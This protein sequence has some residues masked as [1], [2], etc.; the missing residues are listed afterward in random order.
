MDPPCLADGPLKDLKDA[1]YDLYLGAETPTLDEIQAEVNA[2][3][4]SMSAL[5]RRGGLDEAGAE[6]QLDQLEGALPR[7]DTIGRIIG[8]PALPP[9]QADLVV[10]VVALAR[11]AG[12]LP[13]HTI[14]RD[15]PALVTQARRLWRRART[16]PVPLRLGKPIRDCTALAL[17][18]HRAIDLPDQ[19]TDLPRYVPR[20]HDERLREAVTACAGGTSLMITLVGGSSTGK[21][22]ACWEAVQA[23]PAQWRLWHPLDPS[24]P[25]AAASDIAQVGPH[26]VVWLN[27]A[28]FYLLGADLTLNER[29]SAGLR[30]LLNDPGRG[31]VLVLATMWPEYWTALTS[32]PPPD[33]PDR[34]AQARELLAGTDLRIPDSFHGADLRSARSAARSDARLSMAVAQSGSG[35]LTQYLAGVPELVQRCRNAPAAARAVIEAAVD[36]RRFGHPPSLSSELLQAAA[37][38]YLHEVDLGQA[39]PQWVERAFG[40]ALE[41]CHGVAGILSVVRAGPDR[42]FGLFEE[43]AYRL[44]DYL[45]QAGREERAEVFP[46]GAFWD[47]VAA[48]VRDPDVLRRIGERAESRGRNGRAAQLY[49]RSARFGDVGA[50]VAL[51][52]LRQQADD[53][54]GA[55]AF[56]ALAAD[57]GSLEAWEHRA[58]LWELRGHGVDDSVTQQRL[59]EMTERNERFDELYGDWMGEDEVTS[60]LRRARRLSDAG[61]LAQ[62]RELYGE[63]TRTGDPSAMAELATISE[64]L[65]DHVE[66][67]R[68]ALRAARAGKA[69]AVV[70]VV[71]SRES[72]G[73]ADDAEAL[74]VEAGE[75]GQP[76][77]LYLLAEMRPAG[78]GDSVIAHALR[79]GFPHIYSVVAEYHYK[80]DP[81]RSRR[82]HEKAA[83]LGD[84]A[85]L[86]ALALADEEAKQPSAAEDLAVRAADRGDT[87]ALVLLADR[88][89]QEGDLDGAERLYLRAAEA[90]MRGLAHVHEDRGDYERAEELLLA[91][92]NRGNDAVLSDLASLHEQRGDHAGADHVLRFG[93]DDEGRPQ[94]PDAFR[95]AGETEPGGPW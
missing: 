83:D 28:Q 36:A 35:R 49:R 47:A 6:E 67:T 44:A 1:I 11:M 63:A 54:T 25:A 30:A 2:L 61:E 51:G 84:V 20:A 87:R 34:H 82:M 62:A 86:T 74:A 40:Y 14:R 39:G 21:T 58:S 26:T 60:M 94:D 77:A 15:L 57:R 46:P 31:P 41:P 33:V 38:G 78:N 12:R 19:A 23:L 29:I 9:S 95:A 3:G 75:L 24:R 59:M 76:A 45:E 64:R 37:R 13:A 65:G 66:A 73:R 80:T 79:L 10:V 17:E 93:L 50:L 4:D 71:R 32:R 90:G 48:S 92:I 81:E 7:R 55:D 22:R 85:A 69:D 88:R 52:R 27:E 53:L 56:Y 18:V 42:L 72:R 91:V 8:T 5:L 16:A 89:E 70:A 68:Q 43:P